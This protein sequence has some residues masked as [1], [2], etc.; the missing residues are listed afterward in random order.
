MGKVQKEKEPSAIPLAE[1]RGH[2]RRKRRGDRT[3]QAEIHGEAAKKIVLKP[4]II[5][6]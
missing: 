1:M 3:R 4:V 2:A 6:G 5:P